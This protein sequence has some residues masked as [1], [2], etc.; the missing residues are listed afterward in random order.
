MLA[1][2]DFLFEESGVIV[3][4]DGK[5]K[6][7]EEAD[8]PSK[9]DRLWQEKR[10]QER[11]E[12]LG[13]EVVRLTWADLVSDRGQVDARIRRAIPGSLAPRRMISLVR[14]R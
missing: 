14:L 12:D 1:E 4:I 2:V 11:L 9:R 8:R 13:Y 3:E 5:V 6:Y 10:R 7:V